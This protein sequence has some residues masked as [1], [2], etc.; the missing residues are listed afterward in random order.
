MKENTIHQVVVPEIEKNNLILESFEFNVNLTPFELFTSISPEN[1]WMFFDSSLNVEDYGKY[2]IIA[3]FP[4]SIIYFDG[5]NLYKIIN[6][7]KFILEGKPFDYLQ[8]FLQEK[9]KFIDLNDQTINTFFGGFAGFISYDF[10][11]RIENV[12]S[13]KKPVT[14]VPEI[15][16]GY[17]D[18]ALIYNHEKRN[19]TAYS[20]NSVKKF[21]DRIFSRYTPTKKQKQSFQPTK[22]NS[23]FTKEEYINT[24]KKAL[25]YIAE[26]EVYQINL[27]QQFHCETELH[28]LEIYNLL[29]QNNPAPFSALI[30]INNS[31]WILSTSPELFLKVK[32]GVV[33]TK[34]IKGTI[35]RGK[36]EEEDNQLKEKLHSS[37]KDNAE[38]LMIVDLERNDL[39]KVCKSGSVKVIHLKKVETY[40]SVHHLVAEIEGELEEGKNIFDLLLATFPGGSITGAP[41][42]RAIEIIDELEKC[43]RGIYTGSIGYISLNG[44]AMFNISIRTLYYENKQLFLGLGGGIVIDSNPEKEYEETIHK[45]KAIFESL[46]ENE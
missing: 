13:D 25:N 33:K 8:K 22:F 21:L 19:Y 39:G 26:G 35:Q 34:P 42:K 28:P 32:N 2:S 27:S 41:K 9:R 29:R 7:E 43:K 16:F 38:L 15:Y 20:T 5:K 4:D 24:V 17:F 11:L 12:I 6:E 44:D 3:P 1:G 18:S 30:K 36:T 23:N 45:G 37:I 46:S 14:Y 10:G 40:K 31:Q